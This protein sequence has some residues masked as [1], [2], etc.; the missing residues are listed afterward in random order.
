MS[1]SVLSLVFIGGGVIQA[2]ESAT[3]GSFHF[4]GEGT[5]VCDFASYRR[6][7]T[8][9]YLRP[10]QCRLG[11]LTSFFYCLITVTT[12]GCVLCPTDTAAMEASSRQ[13]MW[14]ASS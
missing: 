11:L 7:D 1:L 10:E 12:V 3:P 13:R 6:L 14:R 8:P 2:V 5:D 4:E 9:A